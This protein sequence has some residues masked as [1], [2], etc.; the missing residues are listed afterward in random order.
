M[1]DPFLSPWRE[2]Y[3]NSEKQC[4]FWTNKI[5]CCAKGNKSMH[6][7]RKVRTECSNSNWIETLN[8]QLPFTKQ[9]GHSALLRCKIKITFF[10]PMFIDKC[11]LHSNYWILIFRNWHF[12]RFTREHR[13]ENF[14]SCFAEAPLRNN[15]A[16]SI[17][18]HDE[19]VNVNFP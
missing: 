17:W 4:S 1:L 15:F 5:T 8:Q 19:T 14:M 2:I 3:I 12:H 6:W 9:M 7:I 18:V 10:Q 13:R 16:F 11:F